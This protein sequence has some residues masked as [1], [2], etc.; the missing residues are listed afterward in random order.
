MDYKKA[1]VDIGAGEEF[2]RLIKG[3]VRQTNTPGVITD[4]GAF[5]G[6]F[7][8]DF[9][10]YQRPVMVSSIDGV[11]TK[12]KIAVELGAYDTVGSC[13]VNHC[14]ND[15]LV[16]GAKP[17]FFLDYYACG[18]LDPEVAAA[19]VSGMVDACRENGCALIGGE[20][21]EMP[22]VYTLEDFDLAGTIVGVVDHAKIV[23]G[24]RI[25]AGDVMIA[26]PSTGLHTNG[27]SLARKVFEGRMN[28]TFSGLQGTVG[29][30]LL[31]VH[32]SY[33]RVV[34]PFFGSPDIHG[35]SHIT[36]GGLMGNTMRIVPDGLRLDV[37]WD[38]WP[39]LPIFDLIR[40]EGSV[41]EEDMRR[42]FNLG[43][44]LVLIV[45]P[46]ASDRVMEALKSQGE[47]AYLIGQVSNA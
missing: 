45:A 21:A 38:A 29:Q 30:E 11:G 23:N 24:S 28:E 10:S 22:G 37:N 44:G 5:G 15:I 3:K 14:V 33:L 7:E 47:N 20:T 27:Y 25:Q 42:T 9:A 18:K 19:V 4:I 1:G 36:G 8:P 34:E 17:L 13:L 43:I 2:V 39:E 31:K 6:F 40:R 32:R 26:L 41:P 12:L 35:L 16:C 46:D